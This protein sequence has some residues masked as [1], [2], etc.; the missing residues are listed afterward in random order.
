MH[1]SIETPRQPTV[2]IIVPTY[3]R[4]DDL[5]RL[6]E[7]LVPQIETRPHIRLTVVN[8]GTH[9]P[10]YASVMAPYQTRVDYLIRD[11]SGGC[12]PARQHGLTGAEE[13]YIV[14][15]DDDC[16]AP[17]NWAA[18]LDAILSR[19]PEVDIISGEVIFRASERPRLVERYFRATHERFASLRTRFG[20]VKIATPCSVMRRATLEQCGGFATDYDVA[21]DFD[22]SRRLMA[23]GGTVL[24]DEDWIIEHKSDHTLKGEMRRYYRYGFYGARYLLREQDWRS[25]PLY[26][27]DRQKVRARFER[28]WVRWNWDAIRMREVSNFENVALMTVSILILAALRTGWYRG[29]HHFRNELGRDLPQT[30]ALPDQLSNCVF[31]ATVRR[32]QLSNEPPA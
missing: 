11:S 27:V 22:L 15:T 5:R 24:L 26:H 32:P 12:G 14:T 7:S 4:A 23:A 21:E 3:K 20:F 29:L 9:S 16:I 10:D 1:S 8:D 2:R 13:D 6:L 17:P 28:G 31:G 25:L 30:P 19:H 18:H